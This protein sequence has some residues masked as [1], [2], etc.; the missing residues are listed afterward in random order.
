MHNIRTELLNGIASAITAGG[1]IPMHDAESQMIFFVNE[2]TDLN[3]DAILT[4]VFGVGKFGVRLKL[5]ND[6]VLGGSEEFAWFDIGDGA[7]FG[8]LLAHI[9]ETSDEANNDP[10]RI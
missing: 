6:Y 9:E 5:R 3:A 1:C 2:P 10:T 8:M 4:Y 7:N